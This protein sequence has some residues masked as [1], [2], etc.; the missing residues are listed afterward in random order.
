MSYQGLEIGH[1]GV[2]KFSDNGQFIETI[3]RINHQYQYLIT[4]SS[5]FY[6]LNGISV[7]A[8]LKGFEV[9]SSPIKNLVSGG[10]GLYN[11]FPVRKNQQ[12]TKLHDNIKFRLYPSKS[13]AKIGKNVFSE[14]YTVSLLSKQLPSISEGSPVYYHK[15]PIGEVSHFAMD[16]NG[17][18]RTTLAIKG[19]YKHLIED[20]SVFWN[21][22]GI[23]VDA[24]LSGVKVEADSLLSV[25]SGGIAV[26]VAS[27][28]TNNRFES[29]EFRL[30]ESNQQATSP[31]KEITIIFDEAYELQIGTKLRLKGLEV[32]EIISLTLNN[33]QQ[34]QAKAE[35]QAQ[36]IKQVSK[37][38]TRFW[39]IRS[40]LSLAGAKNLSTIITGVYLNVQ[41]GEGKLTTQFIGE[42]NAP[43]IANQKIG[44]PIILVA[45]NA[46]ATEI[47]SPVYHRQIQIGEVVD[48]QLNDSFSV[49]EITL[50]IYPKYTHVIRENSIFWPASGFNLDIGITGASLK[51]TSLT[52]LIKGGVNMST[53]DN[54]ALQPKAKAFSK[55]N[56]KTYFDED[57]LKWKLEIPK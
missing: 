5:Q 49:A 2:M 37:Q 31:A 44:L 48:K 30:F 54:K 23:K 29:G 46:G 36:F 39:I 16:K 10:I 41:P 51:S 24:G 52:S 7:K 17:L 15:F 19:Q 32:G 6:L 42:A 38:N 47:G 50:N 45:D 14:P 43:L 8:S 9:Q 33:K 57:W 34:V 25:I 22:S 3:I 27:S 11:K 40:E 55:Y 26:D 18:M 1:I 28:T 4:S 35:I 12:T 53:P 21:V 13:M 56:L 20:R